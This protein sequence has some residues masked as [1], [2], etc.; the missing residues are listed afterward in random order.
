MNDDMINIQQ[1]HLNEFFQF[2]FQLVSGNKSLFTFNFNSS[3]GGTTNPKDL[4]TNST[5]TLLISKTSYKVC[6]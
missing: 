6:C 4:A 1:S 2:Y 5:F 3:L